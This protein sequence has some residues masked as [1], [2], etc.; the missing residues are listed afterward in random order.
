MA[1]LSGLSR[2]KGE[3][4]EG[5]RGEKRSERIP[6]GHRREGKRKWTLPGGSARVLHFKLGHKSTNSGRANLVMVFDTTCVLK[7]TK[8]IKIKIC[9]SP[10][11]RMSL[12]RARNANAE[13]SKTWTEAAM[14][15]CHCW[16]A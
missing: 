8:K 9:F 10:S 11:K 1:D 3:S 7:I 6:F 14:S 2:V 16:N 15:H 12:H 5:E 13:F 4:Q